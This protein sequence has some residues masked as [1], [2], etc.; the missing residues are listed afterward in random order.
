MCTHMYV[1]NLSCTGVFA[2]WIV[3]SITVAPIYGDAGGLGGETMTGVYHEPDRELKKI[4]SH[5]I[6]QKRLT[7]SLSCIKTS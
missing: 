3:F 2:W 1:F 5:L 4:E 7:S 6:T